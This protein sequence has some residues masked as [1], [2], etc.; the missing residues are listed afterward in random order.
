MARRVPAMR[1]RRPANLGSMLLVT[2]VVTML[3]CVILIKSRELNEK[4]LA[5]EKRNNYLIERIEEQQKRS[6][7]IE[8]YRKYMQTK[9]YVE[10]MAKSRLGLVYKDEIIFEAVDD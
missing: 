1:V 2:V 5:Y 6:E 8:E 3:L 4:K 7:E 10:D 9:Q